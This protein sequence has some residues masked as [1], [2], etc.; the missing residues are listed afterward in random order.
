M[1]HNVEI[2]AVLREPE[3]LRAR[4]EELADEGPE[5]L[6]QADTF[7]YSRNGRLKLRRLGDRAELIYYE[8]ADAQEPTES[9][10][11]K[12]AV[13]DG[14][15]IEAMLSVALEVRGTVRKRRWLYRVGQT[16]I[17]VDEVEGLGHFLE[18][19]VVLGA[20]QPASEGR[21]IARELMASIGVDEA[22]LVAGAYID[23]LDAAAEEE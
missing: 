13:A 18:L 15:A 17:H 20:S 1:A 12:T 19:E 16:R 4:L 22:D 3:A 11:L 23:L 8:R 6:S 7:F 10:Y 5:L 21:A 9:Q 2:K 14:A